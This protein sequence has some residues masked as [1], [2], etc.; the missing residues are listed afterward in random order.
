MITP[1]GQSQATATTEPHAQRARRIQPVRGRPWKT[2][3]Y[4]DRATGPDVVRYAS[5]D[6][7]T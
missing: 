6:T 7:T 3:G 4:A 2:S 5:V 1:S